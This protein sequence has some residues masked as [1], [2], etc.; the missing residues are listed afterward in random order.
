MTRT[1]SESAFK[2]GGIVWRQDLAAAMGVN[3]Q[4]NYY[5]YDGLQQV[6]AH[7]RSQMN[8]SKYGPIKPPCRRP[9]IFGFSDE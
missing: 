9:R 5:W 4:D 1:L 2:L 6:T 7:Q 3:T 8:E